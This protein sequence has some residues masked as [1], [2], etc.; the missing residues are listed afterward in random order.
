MILLDEHEYSVTFAVNSSWILTTLV[1][2]Q[3]SGISKPLVWLT[4][5][6]HDRS[7]GGLQ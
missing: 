1:Q 3:A 5:R 6:L 7:L 2:W 4:L